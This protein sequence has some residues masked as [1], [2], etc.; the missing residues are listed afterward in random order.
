MLLCLYSDLLCIF[1]Q[2]GFLSFGVEL[3]KIFFVVTFLLLTLLGSHSVVRQVSWRRQISIAS[4]YRF[5]RERGKVPEE[6]DH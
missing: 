3:H 1:N 5:T 4:R 6:N 2:P